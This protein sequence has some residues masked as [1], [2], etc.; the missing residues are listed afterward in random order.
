[1]WGVGV[2]PF[3]SSQE[4][5]EDPGDTVDP[6]Y[7]MVWEELSAGTLVVVRP[8]RGSC[9]ESPTG[10]WVCDRTVRSSPLAGA[11]KPLW[12]R[13]AFCHLPS[14][15]RLAFCYLLGIGGLHSGQGYRRRMQRNWSCGTT[16]SF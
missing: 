5:L 12:G 4:C 7:G 2:P 9:L 6:D 14:R 16:S 8:C 13:L 3:R 15:S 10:G 1:M 11:P